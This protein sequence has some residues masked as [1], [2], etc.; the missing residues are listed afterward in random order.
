MP[1]V[2]KTNRITFRLGN[3][4]GRALRSYSIDEIKKLPLYISVS[5]H[6]KVV[7]KFTP[8]TRVEIRSRVSLRNL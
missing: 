7:R 1:L 8:P 2:S 5:L 3:E 4:I 6:R